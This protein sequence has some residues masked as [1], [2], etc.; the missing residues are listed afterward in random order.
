VRPSDQRA[1]KI[2]LPE[3]VL[4]DQNIDET[5]R[6]LP[7]VTEEALA[8]ENWVGTKAV[9]SVAAITAMHARDEQR[10]SE[11]MTEIEHVTISADSHRNMV[12]DVVDQIQ[13]VE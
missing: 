9:Y 2:E 10:A 5:R 6:I 7:V 11:A 12:A 1:E 13:P 3:D 8:S 4:E